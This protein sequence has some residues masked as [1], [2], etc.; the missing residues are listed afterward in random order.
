MMFAG[1]DKNKLYVKLALRVV[2]AGYIGFLGGQLIYK[3]PPGSSPWF[4]VAAVFFLVVAVAFIVFS[5]IMFFREKASLAEKSDVTDSDAVSAHDE[6]E[7]S[8]TFSIRDMARYR[9]DDITDEDEE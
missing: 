7:S 9:S 6:D 1:N 5:I 4:M 3:R 8:A 2:V